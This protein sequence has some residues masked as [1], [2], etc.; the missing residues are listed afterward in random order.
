MQVL[1][2][3]IVA[4]P[5][6]VT[7]V[8]T[9]VITQTH[10]AWADALDNAAASGKQAGV[11]MVPQGNP[12]SY[13]GGT[14]AVFPNGS[15]SQDLSIGEIFPGAS[16]GAWSG[17]TGLA[18]SES[19]ILQAGGDAQSR[20]STEESPDGMAYRV[21]TDTNRTS[22]PSLASD[23]IWSQTSQVINGL[24]DLATTFGD[25]Q[26]TTTF[27]SDTIAAHV[28]EYRT[29]ERV[30]D[31]SGTSTIQHFYE[32]GV[33][34]HVAGP[35]N[36]A[37]CGDNCVNVWIGT[38]G[39]NYWSGNCQIFEES[40][41]VDVVNPDA[42]IS[43]TLDYA[44]FDDYMQVWLN[45]EKAWSGPLAD[46]SFP[47]ETAGSCE[48]ETSWE[49]NPNTDVTAN[50]TAGGRLQFRTRTSVTGSG[51]GYARVRIIYDPDKVV[52][53]ESWGP[54]SGLDML[55][56]IEDGFCS[57]TFTCTEGPAT[58]A[59]GCATIDGVKVCPSAFSVP[60]LESV[61]PTCREFQ[62][63][64][65]CNFWIGQMDCW[66]DPDGVQHCPTNSPSG[67]TNC[68]ELEEDPTCG[69]IRTECMQ[70]AEGASGTCYVH[71]EV[72]DCGYDAD[73]GTVT[74]ST[75]LQCA[76]EIRCMGLECT[77]RTFEQSD[78]FARAAAAFDAA[79]HISTDISCTQNGTEANVVC[80]VFK[81]EH[82]ECKKA[83]SGTVDC[84]KD[85]GGGISMFDYITLMRGVGKL[86]TAIMSI[87][88]AGSVG[89]VRDAWVE[90]RQPV[91]DL[92]TTVSDPLVDAWS[93]VW[94]GAGD[95][96]ATEVTKQGFFTTIEQSIMQTSAEFVNS[97]FGEAAANAL[98][99]TAAGGPAV[100]GG[101]VVANTTLQLG[102][103]IGSALSVVM[104]AYS[105]YS[106]TKLI[107]Q[108]IWQ[109]EEK[110]FELS[111]RRQL[112][113]C[114]YAG[115]YC[116]TKVAGYCIES[117]Q[118]Y[119]CF[120]SP[121]SRIIQEQI[122]LQVDKPWGE[123]DSPDCSAVTTEELEQVD[124]DQ[125]DLSE[126]LGIL[127]AEGLLPQ[128]QGL[129]LVS[130]TGVGNTVLQ[131]ANPDVPR[132]D[133]LDRARDRID[134]LDVFQT[135]QDAASAIR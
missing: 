99:Q 9:L 1:L 5:I 64:A 2:N 74:Q 62:A 90:L 36:V 58:D 45:D 47:P 56:S 95:A 59:E 24:G 105:I 81:G 21:L 15:G 13:N 73:V 41:T 97:V 54:P 134:G 116:K 126:W 44:K 101:E 32:S 38:V 79:Q 46:G 51:E 66:T 94:G 133:A 114:H 86:D 93:G 112:K 22:R 76:G 106:I 84:C 3:R 85:F 14:F 39:D 125:I 10:L 124:W 67:L 16:D 127:E 108:I 50:F 75:D 88:A 57:G 27:G 118:S 117:R 40:I 120:N 89:V 68:Q 78:D 82:L 65:S 122:R 11:G 110:E 130:L 72:W 42:I 30:N 135:N 128:D 23:P 98:F 63:E 8:L 132:P 25:C 107:I 31:P 20:L 33:V 61:N 109:C 18:G 111:A 4:M 43:A 131:G 121:L 26:A 129:D 69:F 6:V 87:D 60:P 53:S 104:L 103:A 35:L 77:D 119:C 17:A 7:L 19:D 96:A 71:N 83:V 28:P 29:C 91:A 100:V 37:S 49:L 52:Y 113:S 12:F 115:S 48:L 34:K 80:E 55:S 70:Y 123:P 102:G 92:W